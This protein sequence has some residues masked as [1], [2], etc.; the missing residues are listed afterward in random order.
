MKSNILKPSKSMA[1]LLVSFAIIIILMI[2]V[3]LSKQQ[4][5]EEQFA[6]EELPLIEYNNSCYRNLNFTNFVYSIY[7]ASDRAL[8]SDIKKNGTC[9]QD[10]RS[11]VLSSDMAKIEEHGMKYLLKSLCVN[12]ECKVIELNENQNSNFITLY[13]NN[14]QAS[15]DNSTN[16]LYLFLTNPIYIEFEGSDAY[17]PDYNDTSNVKTTS[18]YTNFNDGIILGNKSNMDI[19]CSFNRLIKYGAT[20]ANSTFN[21]RANGKAISQLDK[22]INKRSAVTINARIYFLE[23]QYNISGV[24]LYLKNQFLQ[25]NTKRI[26]VIKVYNKSYNNTVSKENDEYYF[27]QNIYKLITNSEYPIFTFRFEISIPVTAFNN[28]SKTNMEILKVFMDTNIGAYSTCTEY[29]NMHNN[30]ANILSA[31][32]TRSAIVSKPG[33]VNTFVLTFTTTNNTEN[34]NCSPS[35]TPPIQNRYNKSITSNPTNLHVELPYSVNNERIKVI[36]TAS[37][38]EKITLCKWKTNGREYF[39]FKRSPS[40]N[41]GNNF[42]KVFSQRKEVNQNSIKNEDIH[43]AFFNE[44]VKDINYVQLG[45]TNYL[46]EFYSKM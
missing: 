24:K 35:V 33:N 44:F 15:I 46:E 4:K 40:C 16:I 43:F 32:I 39:I 27:H 20:S 23:N 12:L 25:Q 6:T 14:N 42:A 28:V 10:L 41:I 30:N 22:L 26:G 45:H 31:I 1:A 3:F 13:F 8:E 2:I 11:P 37:P 5:L 34:N 21:Y 29:E 36:I 38:Y 18:Y 19:A 17:V 9:P 7:K